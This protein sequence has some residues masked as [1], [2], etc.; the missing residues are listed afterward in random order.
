VDEIAFLAEHGP[1]M[2]VQVLTAA[3]CGAA[4]GYER[5]RHAAPA[6]MKTCMLV[7]AGAAQYTH[8]GAVLF[9]YEHAGDPSRMASQIVTGIGFLGAGA[10]L[11]GE[12]SVTGLTT[13]AT[14]WFIGGIGVI[15]GSGFSLSGVALT[16]LMLTLLSL[17]RVVERRLFP[18]VARP[19]EPPCPAPSSNE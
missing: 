8:I 19:G 17:M 15:V 4:I 10:I 14:I 11:H 6:G 16:A 3:A 9:G 2:G 1:S 18:R 12:G 7:C 13:A 5:Q